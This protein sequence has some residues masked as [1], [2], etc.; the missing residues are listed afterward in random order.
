LSVVGCP[1]LR[2]LQTASNAVVG[3]C[4]T[5]D[6]GIIEL[7]NYYFVVKRGKLTL[8][9]LFLDACTDGSTSSSHVTEEAL[10]RQ[11]E[12][13]ATIRKPVDRVNG[14]GGLTDSAPL[15]DVVCSEPDDD[16]FPANHSTPVPPEAKEQTIAD[17]Q[18]SPSSAA[19]RGGDV[20]KNPTSANSSHVVTNG[21]H[22]SPTNGQSTKLEPKEKNV[23]KM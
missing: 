6:I 18:T 12:L 1:L 13:Y 8:P 2:N 21:F 15:V 14:L 16:V 4:T 10:H 7:L 11:V 5:S 19:S 3:E 17:K 22:G 20:K 9:S 23:R